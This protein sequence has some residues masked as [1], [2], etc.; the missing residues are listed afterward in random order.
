MAPNR[1]GVV[2]IVVMFSLHAADLGTPILRPLQQ[3]Q[4]LPT[5]TFVRRTSWAH[6]KHRQPASWA[7]PATSLSR[8]VPPGLCCRATAGNRLLSVRFGGCGITRDARTSRP[9][10]VAWSVHFEFHRLFRVL[11]QEYRD[12]RHVLKQGTQVVAPME[13]ELVV[14]SQESEL[15]SCVKIEVDILGSRP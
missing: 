1:Q 10:V 8:P 14:S 6:T 15:R 5:A 9:K 12:Q 7:Y 11:E 2:S 13:I 4:L 3:G